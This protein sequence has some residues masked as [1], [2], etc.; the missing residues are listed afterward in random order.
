[1]KNTKLLF[2]LCAVFSTAA[3]VRAQSSDAI[4]T[5]Q[6]NDTIWYCLYTPKRDA[7]YLTDNGAGNEL[8]GKAADYSDAQNWCFIA[9]ANGKVF[10]KNR[11][12]GAYI[13]DTPTGKYFS[14]QSGIP[15][16]GLSFSTNDIYYNITDANGNMLNQCDGT[17]GFKITTWNKANDPGNLFFVK[18]MDVRADRLDFYRNEAL[19]LLD[20]TLEGDAPGYFP[21]DAREAFHNA[22]TAAQSIEEIDSAKEIYLRSMALVKEG[23]KYFLKSTGPQYANTRV[24]YNT[25][26]TSG[27]TLRYADKTMDKNALW[28][29][30]STEQNGFYLIKNVGNGLY[31]WA[32]DSD[33]ST[34]TTVE[35]G[36]AATFS[37]SALMK[38]LSFLILPKNGQPLHAQENYA[39]VVTW[40]DR[41]YGS[42]SSWQIIP[43]TDE[44]LSLIDSIKAQESKYQTVWQEDFDTDG[45]INTDDWNTS[46]GFI[47]NNEMQWYQP[48]NVWIEDGVMVFEG[49]K[50]HK[51]NPNYDPNSGDW[52][53]NRQY[54]EYT[55]AAV[56]T[57]N[58]H[59]WLY[60][61]FSVRAKIPTASGSWPAIWF[62]GNESVTGPWPSSGEIDLMEY[63][64]GKTLANTVWGSEAQWTGQ[65]ETGGGGQPLSYWRTQN[66][67]WTDEYHIWKMEW[68]KEAIKLYLDS[69]LVTVC[70]LS[71][72]I[73]KGTWWKVENPFHTNQ[74]LLLNLALG[75]DGGGTIDN[76]ALPMR[77]LVDYVHIEQIQETPTSIDHTELLPNKKDSSES[78]LTIYE[79]NGK[80]V[81]HGK[82]LPIN[83]LGLAPGLYIANK[84]KV[85]IK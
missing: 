28:T 45:A 74:Y 5:S 30:E 26:A 83:K 78:N 39:H 61:R 82:H 12:T 21:K 60:G 72:T 42:A 84:Q 79:V 57:N 70:H 73:N 11:A 4:E 15:N 31:M 54:I 85:L 55:S 62:L 8:S 2:A 46:T 66:P 51:P 32:D 23:T 47:R 58:K 52:R 10:M 33:N 20:T 36:K 67:N 71:R 63:Y 24:I 18:K 27:A 14:T 13:T 17:Q 29:F 35:K 65:W 49:R 50:E 48:E 68:T 53:K 9:S 43:A 76:S 38:D 56:S 3:S 19:K 25:K 69:E 7:L 22:L 34:T 75:G 6:E 40:N 59:D 64:K 81:Y 1:M 37:L 44:E 41:A 16:T 77:Y 80:Q